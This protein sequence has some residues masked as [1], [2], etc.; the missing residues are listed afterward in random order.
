M[1]RPSAGGPAT[2]NG[3]EL[4]TLVTMIPD[5]DKLERT[6]AAAPDL[7]ATLRDTAFAV[8]D[9]DRYTHSKVCAIRALSSIEPKLAY[10]AAKRALQ[11]KKIHDRDYYPI[12]LLTID[13]E[14]AR[15]DLFEQML[16]ETA[17]SVC[18]AIGRA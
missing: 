9:G 10:E 11:D 7:T 4:E 16:V 1:T 12:L 13:H 2:I 14:C 3:N 15:N 18:A 17:S 6:F 5:P 8:E